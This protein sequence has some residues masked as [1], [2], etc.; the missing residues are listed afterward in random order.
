MP[1]ATIES[2]K[3]TTDGLF[4][5]LFSTS[6]SLRDGVI[7]IVRKL[8]PAG[9]QLGRGDAEPAE[10][11]AP[12]NKG[13]LRGVLRGR[14]SA[15]ARPSGCSRSRATSAPAARCCRRTPARR[16]R[17][18][19]SA[20]QLSWPGR[21]RSASGP[22]RAASGSGRWP[23]DRRRARARRPRLHP[24]RRHRAGA[25][26]GARRRRGRGGLHRRPGRPRPHAGRHDAVRRPCARLRAA[27][28]RRRC[29]PVGCR[30]LD[31]RPP[32]PARRH[33]RPLRRCTRLGRWAGGG[34]AAAARA[35]RP[36]PARGGVRRT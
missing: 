31:R 32:A 13:D 36:A 3:K 29:G 25:A 5:V 33:D 27:R 20:D 12:F 26:P 16:P 1:G 35:P 7:F 8:P 21:L 4:I 9:F 14:P 10:A 34:R 24:R 22:R 17:R 11:D 6:T 23:G 19:R 15:S 30:G 2:S 18:C 28:A